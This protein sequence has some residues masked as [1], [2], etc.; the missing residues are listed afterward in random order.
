LIKVKRL[1][2]PLF[3]RVRTRLGLCARKLACPPPHRSILACGRAA[4]PCAKGLAWLPMSPSPHRPICFPAFVFAH[5]GKWA[6]A[7]ATAMPPAT[8]HTV[9]VLHSPH[10]PAIRSPT[11][12]GFTSR[13]IHSESNRRPWR[14]WR[15]RR[16]A[17]SRL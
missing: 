14:R 4:D 1:P 11:T 3:I 6:K 16:A 7:Q 12:L 2:C 5:F 8:A 9:P 10:L 15:R 13:S 17:R